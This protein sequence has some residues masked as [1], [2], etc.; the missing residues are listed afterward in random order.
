[1]YENHRASRV[2]ILSVAMDAQGG[3]KAGPYVEK[4]KAQFVTVVDEENLLGQLYG[5][6]AI[7]NG[8]FIEADGTVAYKELGT[9]NILKSK[10]A[11]L[12]EEWVRSAIV[13]G[14]NEGSE[15]SLGPEHLESNAYFRAG[16]RLYREGKME[17]AIAHWRK[18]VELEPDNYIIRKQIWA[19]QNPSKFY[20]GEVD[21][22]WQAEQ[23][24]K[25]V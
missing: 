13:D 21:Y 7:P 18:G 16:M 4:A 15:G 8:F 12:V 14:G 3:E 22:N 6:K 2:E 1:M 10:T 19:V 20:A 24:A 5:F 11:S 25:G 9:F 23:L 17:E